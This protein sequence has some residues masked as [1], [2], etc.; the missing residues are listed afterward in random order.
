MQTPYHDIPWRKV[1]DDIVFQN[2][3][4]TLHNDL[5]EKPDENQISFL[6]IETKDYTTVFCK[7]PEN[8]IV[9]VRQ[10]RYAF[11][12]FSWECPG[13]IVDNGEE[14][15][16]CAM[17]E[18]LEET[19]YRVTAIKEVLKCHPNAYS[20]AWAYTFLAT[21]EKAGEQH[22]DDNEYILVQEFTEE[23]AQELIEKGDFVHGPS[24]ICL[25]MSKSNNLQKDL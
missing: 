24:L 13:G 17:R 3:Y 22:L 12:K 5:V 23:E 20:T 4:L 14:P 2:K 9:L 21:V 8:K 16:Q 7:T 1:K 11:E 18:V 19:G 6:K 25:L 15:R 10:Y